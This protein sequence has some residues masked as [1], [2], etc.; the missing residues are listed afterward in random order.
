M[1]NTHY[2][3][4]SILGAKIG[5]TT[6]TA[7]HALGE[8]CKGD[9][10]TEWVYVQAN[11]AITQYDYVCMDEDFQAVAGTKA[12]VDAGHEIGFAQVAFANDEYGWIARRGK[13]CSVR[14]AASCAPD[15][16]LYTTGT[17]GVLDDASTSQSQIRGVVIISTAGTAT[18]QA[19]ECIAT[20]PLG[21]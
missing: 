2:Q 14:V 6:T 20:Y 13:T 12:L 16:A 8:T 4:G 1:A 15:V 18:A 11:G 9:N 5:T 21:L 17:A 19:V 7:E 10:G 3:T